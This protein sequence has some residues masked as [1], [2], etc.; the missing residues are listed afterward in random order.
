VPPVRGEGQ[1]AALLQSRRN[2]GGRSGAVASP[3]RVEGRA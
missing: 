3:T 2:G 1:S